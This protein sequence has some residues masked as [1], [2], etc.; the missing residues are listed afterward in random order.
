MFAVDLT[1]CDRHDYVRR[2]LFFD[3]PDSE[4][5][6]LCLCDYVNFIVNFCIDIDSVVTNVALVCPHAIDLEDVENWI[7]FC[8][9][10][11]ITEL[12]INFIL[13]ADQIATN[14]RLINERFTDF[15]ALVIFYDLDRWQWIFNIKLSY[16][17]TNDFNYEWVFLHY[18][19]PL[20]ILEIS[21][22]SYFIFT[23]R[24]DVPISFHNELVF[25]CLLP[26][27]E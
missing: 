5:E 6:R 26:I 23:N 8:K 12:H 21:L 17:F 1:C 16:I 25:I 2:V 20:V 22:V 10:L 27:F 4:N 7:I 19:S 9:F 14:F 24:T 15:H 13:V 3:L 11:C 18:V